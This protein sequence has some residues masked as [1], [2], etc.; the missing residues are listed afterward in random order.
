MS[1]MVGLQNMQSVKA[2]EKMYTLAGLQKHEAGDKRGETFVIP[3]VALFV[4][5]HGQ[6]KGSTVFKTSFRAQYTKNS[7]NKKIV[8]KFNLTLV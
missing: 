1:T 8:T 2:R 5:R 3:V 4:F 7:H 6:F